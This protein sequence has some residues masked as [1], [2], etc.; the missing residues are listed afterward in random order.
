MGLKEVKNDPKGARKAAG[1]LIISAS[2]EAD[3]TRE[4]L[5]RTPARFARAMEH[6][7]SGYRLNVQDAVGEGV[8]AAEGSGLVTVASIEFYSLCEHHLLPFWGTVSVAYFPKSKILG[9]SKIPRIVEVF[10]R[11]LQVQER[12]TREVAEAIRDAIDPRAVAVRARASHMCMMMRGVEK[13]NSTTTTEVQFGVESLSAIE[14][15]RFW[16]GL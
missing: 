10:A 8:F 3:P 7:M 15:S 16:K 1:E 5:L 11:R 12:F 14:Q 9:L 4:G 6:M 2:G 13:Q